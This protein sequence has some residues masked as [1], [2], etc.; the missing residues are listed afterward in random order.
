MIKAV[1]LDY[2]GTISAEYIDHVI[3]HKPYFRPG[4][5]VT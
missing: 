3:G 5:R 2:G 1:A 4:R